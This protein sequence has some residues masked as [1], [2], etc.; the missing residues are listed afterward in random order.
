VKKQNILNRIPRYAIASG[1]EL[2]S[3]SGQDSDIIQETVNKVR[4]LVWL[5][6]SRLVALVNEHI[7]IELNLELVLPFR[8]LQLVS[9]DSMGNRG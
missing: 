7:G 2:G 4:V 9:K 3:L 5:P 8:I 1:W 6:V